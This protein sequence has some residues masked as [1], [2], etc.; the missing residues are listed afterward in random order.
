MCLLHLAHQLQQT[1]STTPPIE[2]IH[3]NHGLQASAGAWQKTV[4]QQS[5]VYGFTCHSRQV[6]ITDQDLQQSGV[7]AAARDARYGVFAELV[8]DGDVVLLAQHADDQ[9]ETFMLRLLRGAGV[10]GLGAMPRQRPLGA[11][12]LC[13]PLL[14]VSRR[15]IEAYAEEQQL[16]WVEDPSNSDTRFERNYLR[17]EIMP[18]LRKRWPS[19]A[20][21]IATSTEIMQDT[22]DLLQ[23]LAAEDL[24]RCQGDTKLQGGKGLLVDSV[25]ALSSSRRN[26]LLR[27]WLSLQ[28]D[29]IPSYEAL[30]RIHD[31]VLLAA[32][33]GQPEI[34]LGSC[35]VKRSYGAIY[36]LIEQSIGQWDAPQTLVWH[37][38]F[39]QQQAIPFAG[40]WLVPANDGISLKQGDVLVA[41]KRR[42][43]ERC[44]PQGRN[45]SQSLKKLLQEYQVPVWLRETL[46]L[47]YRNDELVMVANHWLCEGCVSESGEAAWRWLASLDNSD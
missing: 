28:V 30:Q 21:R 1:D 35:K 27:H 24:L 20:Q 42:G 46:P 19:V 9:A 4:E 16:T 13:R 2:V 34:V 3:V 29:E 37:D 40:G 31:E 6:T 36:C 26:N 39:A 10:A 41:K 44:Q 8:N 15:Q 45:H 38:V 25:L 17:H 14:N 5:A 47:I 11:G 32:V 7:E 12:S 22:Q 23:E 43:G 33:D 18:G